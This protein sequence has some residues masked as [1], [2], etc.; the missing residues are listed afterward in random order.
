MNRNS[1]PNYDYIRRFSTEKLEELLRLTG[2]EAPTE[3]DDA[4]A[5]A[6]IAELLRREEGDTGPQIDVDQ[7]WRDFQTKFNTPDAEPR[8]ELAPAADPAVPVRR[9]RRLRAVLGVAAALVLLGTAVMPPALGYENV[10]QMIGLW[11]SEHFTF[12]EGAVGNTETSQERQNHQLPDSDAEYPTMEE[13]LEAYGI[14]EP[15]MPV[16]PEG[17]ELVE[18][19]VFPVD[20][21]WQVNIDAFYVKEEDNISISVAQ[22]SEEYLGGG[23]YEKDDEPVELYE[24]GGVVH[25]MFS[26][27]AGAREAA[28]WIHGNLQCS[29]HTTMNRE[30]L[31]NLVNSI[32]EG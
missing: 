15:V 3:E 25:Y 24:T 2:G 13:A 28:V 1:S 9:K 8:V 27:G 22:L 19:A 5:G 11:N 14:T 10:F 12:E 18:L 23:T 26:N 4:L 20:D 32:Y 6:V 29:I 7:A 31:K 21:E 17:Y 16:I 30:E